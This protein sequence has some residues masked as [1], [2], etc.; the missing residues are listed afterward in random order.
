[1]WPLKN[2]SCIFLLP[3]LIELKIAC[4]E[5][6]GT[7]KELEPFQ[8]TTPLQRLIFE[9]S[10]LTP[11]ALS[12]I[13]AT[14][15]ALEELTLGENIHNIGSPP[16]R[17]LGSSESQILKTM[18]AISKVA[19]SLSCLVHED[20]GCYPLE[21][22]NLPGPGLRN[23]HRLIHLRCSKNSFLF[24]Y[25]AQSFGQAPMN[26][27]HLTL[28]GHRPKGRQ[29]EIM[30]NPVETSPLIRLPDLVKVTL[31]QDLALCH[32]SLGRRLWRP[33]RTRKFHEWAYELHTEGIRTVLDIRVIT[34]NYYP[35]YAYNE[36]EPFALRVYDSIE[37]SEP[38]YRQH[39]FSFPRV[40]KVF[41][42]PPELWI[43]PV[44]HLRRDLTQA[45]IEGL[46]SRTV[47][48]LNKTTRKVEYWADIGWIFDG[49][50]DDDEG[51]DD[52]DDHDGDN[53]G[54]DDNEEDGNEE[55]ENEEDG[56]EEDED[57][58]DDD[59]EEGNEDELEGDPMDVD[60]M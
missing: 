51:D 10:N 53:G 12:S 17:S 43:Q 36:P 57:E 16:F 52:N 59:I 42:K 33:E 49:W 15:K 32:P 24:R 7:I 19:G 8:R 13:L 37:I 56:N 47:F 2:F 44:L 22:M 26:L 6:T 55:D 38:D 39:W 30:E 27:Q 46:A 34:P 28:I 48:I 1:M 25:I 3:S 41:G 31:Q 11:A 9:E 21:P 29:I 50:D 18:D 5:I 14:P 4:V 60:D 23:F 20:R 54:E 35:P 58:D 40:R 45:M